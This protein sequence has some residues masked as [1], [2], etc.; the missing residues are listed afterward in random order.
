[1]NAAFRLL[2]EG[3]GTRQ[4]S[5]GYFAAA[6]ASHPSTLELGGNNEM[7]IRRRDIEARPIGRRHIA[8]IVDPERLG[9]SPP[10]V[11]CQGESP[12][13][14]TNPLSRFGTHR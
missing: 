1:M 11:P 4:P 14:L 6:S 7:L 9:D 5:I 8:F 12:A 3:G 13:H 10:F 2:G